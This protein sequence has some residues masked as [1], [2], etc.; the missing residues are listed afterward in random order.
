MNVGKWMVWAVWLLCACS[1]ETVEQSILQQDLVSKGVVRFLVLG[2]AG[3][4][5]ESQYQVA[6]AMASVCEDQGCDFALYLGDNFY[7]VGVESIDDEQFE[8][9]FEQPYAGLDFPFY[10]VLGNHDYGLLGNEWSQPSSQ[11]EYT[12]RSAKWVLPDRYYRHVH[13]HVSLYGLNS[14]FLKIEE[15]HLRLDKAGWTLADGIA[16]KVIEAL[17]PIASG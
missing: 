15:N 3:E 10:V 17:S 8:S 4:G 9:K 16:R 12:D 2:D 1:D 14:T 13:E 5:N 7:D 6:D 11:V